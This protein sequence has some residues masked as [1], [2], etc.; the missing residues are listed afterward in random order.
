M[1]F[2]FFLHCWLHAGRENRFHPCRVSPVFLSN[3]CLSPTLMFFRL[4]EAFAL[5]SHQSVVT[6]CSCLR[7]LSPVVSCILV[8]SF[9]RF[10]TCPLQAYLN[11]QIFLQITS[12]TGFQGPYSQRINAMMWES[13]LDSIW[14]VILKTCFLF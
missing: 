6:V 9:A 7:I 14:K 10:W 8:I 4:K 5:L 13:V 11:I 12:F 2:F 1:P 3:I